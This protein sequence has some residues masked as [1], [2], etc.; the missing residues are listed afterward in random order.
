M[1]P[2]RAYKRRVYNIM[3]NMNRRA[4][5]I[6]EMRITKLRPTTD[7][8]TVWMNIHCTPVPGAAKVDWYKAINDN[9]PTNDWLYTIRIAPTDQCNCGMHCAVLH[10]IIEC[11]GPQIWQWTTQKIA[12]ILRTIP[13]RI[14]SDW[15]LRSQCTLWLPMRRCAVMWILANVVL[16]RTGQNR[17]LTLRDLM[18]FM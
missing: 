18:N 7:W 15:L 13:T 4:T 9:L 1:E 2:M 6:Q 17:E 8:T 16:F 11:G 3:Y 12:L 14:P 5:G 10:R